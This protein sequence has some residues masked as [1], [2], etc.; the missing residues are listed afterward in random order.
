MVKA[1]EEI[2][3]TLKE[4]LKL[5]NVRD[6][7]RRVRFAG[8]GAAVMIQEE[9]TDLVDRIIERGEAAEGEGFKLIDRLL[10]KRKDDAKKA[11]SSLSDEIDSR[12]T[13]VLSRLNLTTKS[14]IEALTKHLEKLSSQVD[15]LGKKKTV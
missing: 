15:K 8:I 3:D 11:V 2:K 7:L 12:W 14:D 5:E 1:V 9:L 4:T 13:K 6:N 10:G